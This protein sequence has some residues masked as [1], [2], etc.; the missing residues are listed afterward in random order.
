MHAAEQN[1]VGTIKAVLAILS[2]GLQFCHSS[3]MCVE[4]WQKTQ[5]AGLYHDTLVLTS[6]AGS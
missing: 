1:K 3:V 5:E 2:W 6:A 4:V